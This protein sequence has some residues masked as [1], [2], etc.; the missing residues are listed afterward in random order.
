MTAHTLCSRAEVAD[1]AVNVRAELKIW[2]K[3]FSS[4]HGGRKAGRDDIKQNPGIGKSGLRSWI[5][6]RVMIGIS[7]FL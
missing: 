1:Q 2:E 6:L 7:L 5:L 4:T 3:E